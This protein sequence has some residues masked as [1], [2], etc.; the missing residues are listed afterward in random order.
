MAAPSGFALK[1]GPISSGFSLDCRGWIGNLVG[2]SS[3]QRP[4][5]FGSVLDA[6]QQPSAPRA[7]TSLV[8]IV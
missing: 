5:L 4:V 6:N 3:M 8:G 2:Q 7:S 1:N